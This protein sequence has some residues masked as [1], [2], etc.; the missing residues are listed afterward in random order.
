MYIRTD[1]PYQPTDGKVTEMVFYDP[2]TN[3]WTSQAVTPPSGLT[4]VVGNSGIYDP[5]QN[6]LMI[7]GSQHIPEP[8]LFLYRYSKNG[9]SGVDVTPPSPPTNLNIN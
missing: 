9:G 7:T 4:S 5:N 2:A 1:S 3:A 6:V 8:Y